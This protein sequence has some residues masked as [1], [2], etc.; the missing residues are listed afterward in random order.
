MQSI[1]QGSRRRGERDVLVNLLGCDAG[2]DEAREPISTA[3]KDK[4]GALEDF[5][6][7]ASHRDLKRII[8]DLRS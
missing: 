2:H 1:G 4:L 5:L 7:T 3:Y 6:H 8:I